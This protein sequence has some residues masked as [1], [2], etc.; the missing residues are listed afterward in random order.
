MKPR[1][2]LPLPWSPPHLLLATVPPA[3]LSRLHPAHSSSSNSLGALGRTGAMAAAAPSSR[4]PPP[5]P[6]GPWICFN[7][8]AAQGGWQ[9]DHQGA[10][11]RVGPSGLETGQA[12]PA[13]LCPRRRT[14][15]SPRPS[16]PSHRRP[17]GI[18]PASSPL[19]SRCLS[20]AHLRGSWTPAP[21][22]ICTL[23]KVY[24]SPVP[25]HRILLLL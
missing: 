12:R 21:P 25:L 15:P 20:K 8:W 19:F 23:L 17:L 11:A 3:I 13:R 9:A 16:S 22:L 24:C 6:A 5:T 7:P 10:G 1:L 4:H 2:L 18:R 14:L